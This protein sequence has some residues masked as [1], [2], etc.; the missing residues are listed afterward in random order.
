MMMARSLSALTLLA[1]LGGALLPGATGGACTSQQCR[2]RATADGPLL[3][4]YAR[5][6]F[7]QPGP[8]A[9]DG[10]ILALRGSL[11]IQSL[12]RGLPWP[13]AGGFAP[14]PQ[15]RYVAYGEDVTPGLGAASHT[16]G[17]W[18]IGSAGG[19]PRRLL[20]PPRSA[21]GQAVYRIGPVAWSSDQS[22]LAYAVNDAEDYSVN[23][24]S[25][26]VWLTRYDQPRP[27]LLAPLAALGV[28]TAGGAP[29]SQLSWSP[30]GRTL[31]VS[32]ERAG[33]D[34]TQPG[35]RT[36]VVLALDAVT[37]QSRMLVDGGWYASY[38][39]T[40]ASLTYVTGGIGTVATPMAL[41]VADARG[42]HRRKLVSVSGTILSPV[43]SPDGRAIAYIEG[44][45][46]ADRP[47]AIHLLD[48]ITGQDWVILTSTGAGQRL[49]APG[50]RF[51][52]LA[53]MRAWPNGGRP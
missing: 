51:L 31:A 39:P 24:R 11:V 21:S 17:L 38:A 25:L 14:S 37:G 50:G 10:Q 6:G 18:V 30:D 42:Q 29:I 41:W 53:W 36:P 40:G 13:F 20:S 4:L 45:R 2:P 7:G 34:A 48:A 52:R 26:G 23:P 49:F 43:W 27:R 28:M 1:A 19:P 5:G 33:G 9:G 8:V 22:T 3:V 32:A 47:T 46:A 16:E 12:V 15:G 44:G 35:Q